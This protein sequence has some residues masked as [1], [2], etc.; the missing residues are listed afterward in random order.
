MTD[1]SNNCRGTKC[2][3]SFESET[4]I[5]QRVMKRLLVSSPWWWQLHCEIGQY[6]LHPD[7]KPRLADVGK[8]AQRFDAA[9]QNVAVTKPAKL[10]RR[11][12]W[13]CNRPW[14]GKQT[15]GFRKTWQ[16]SASGAK[17]WGHLMK[18]HHSGCFCDV[19]NLPIQLPCLHK[20]CPVLWICDKVT[21]F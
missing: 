6:S 2:C 5:L 14:K 17:T 9:S 16:D 21:S 7:A 20:L 3:A 4:K 15:G 12:L 1:E 8:P 19:P 10:R 18:K 13:W 11:K